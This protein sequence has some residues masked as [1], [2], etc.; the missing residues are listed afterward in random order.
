M[1]FPRWSFLFIR[2]RPRKCLK[3]AFNWL[4]ALWE[5]CR[6]ALLIGRFH[7]SPRHWRPKCLG[8]EVFNTCFLCMNMNCI[9]TALDFVCPV[10]EHQQLWLEPEGQLFTVVDLFTWVGEHL[11]LGTATFSS[12]LSSWLNTELSQEA[13]D[14]LIWLPFVHNK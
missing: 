9:K 6:C 1:E 7:L 12:L 13:Q 3:I 10:P 5:E 14:L 4:D 2:N 8:Q 11:L